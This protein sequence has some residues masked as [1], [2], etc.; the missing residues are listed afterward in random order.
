M[1]ATAEE[2][3]VDVLRNRLDCDATS[4]VRLREIVPEEIWAQWTKIW[5]G[6]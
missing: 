3:A 6:E 1:Q 5:F 4:F 2:I